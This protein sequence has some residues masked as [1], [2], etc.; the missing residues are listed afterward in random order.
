MTTDTPIVSDGRPCDCT[1]CV[2]RV[3]EAEQIKIE[4]EKKIEEQRLKEEAEKKAK[5][6][7]E[8]L[9]KEKE[10]AER[11]EAEKK[12]KEEEERLKKEKEAAER[13]EAEKKEKKSAV[14]LFF[15]NRTPSEWP[16]K[17]MNVHVSV[18][19]GFMEWS[20]NKTFDG[21]LFLWSIN[22]SPRLDFNNGKIGGDYAAA[23]GMVLKVLTWETP[24]L[25][26][27]Y[28]GGS[29]E[30]ME[31]YDYIVSEKI[32]NIMNNAYRTAITSFYSDTQ[33]VVHATE[34]SI[35]SSL[36]L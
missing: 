2:K 15:T 9:K 5:E 22:N 7:E 3:A 27:W 14:P 28:N 6:E 1:Y 32:F 18:P 23:S 12:A 11:A 26:T 19:Q 13:A 34:R 29:I 4:A 33:K 20:Y 16:T 8:H 10:A 21:V 31:N 24:K 35:I 36:S 30:A 25:V 17:I